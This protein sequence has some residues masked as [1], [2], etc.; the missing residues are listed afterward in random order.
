MEVIARKYI[1]TQEEFDR[2]AKQDRDSAQRKIE[3]AAKLLRDLERSQISDKAER[4]AI[5]QRFREAARM[6]QQGVN[7]GKAE[8]IR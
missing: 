8:H 3:H 4:L 6:A 5:T 1:T 7:Y 2:V